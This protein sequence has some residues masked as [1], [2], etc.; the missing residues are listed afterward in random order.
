MQCINL[1]KQCQIFGDGQ[2]ERHQSY[3]PTRR[4]WCEETTTY[5]LALA[6]VDLGEW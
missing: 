1:S 3:Q 2:E 5:C 4:N 6:L